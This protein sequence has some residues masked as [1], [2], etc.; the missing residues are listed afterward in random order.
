[1]NTSAFFLT[2]WKSRLGRFIRSTGPL[3]LQNRSSTL[4]LWH[5]G[6][7]HHPKYWWSLSPNAATFATKK[8]KS[9]KDQVDLPTK[10]IDSGG[11][12]KTIKPVSKIVTPESNAWDTMQRWKEDV[13]S[14]PLLSSIVDEKVPKLFEESIITTVQHLN[15]RLSDSDWRIQLGKCGVVVDVLLTKLKTIFSETKTSGS[16]GELKTTTTSPSEIVT[17]ESNAWDTMQQ[18]KDEIVTPGS[19]EHFD[20]KVPKFF[21]ESN[22]TTVQHLENKSTDGDWCIQLGKCGVMERV[23]LAK[24]KTIF[25]ETKTTGSAGELKTTTA[26]PLEIVTS[27]SNAWDTM[28]Q[29]KDEIVTPGG[30][31]H[32]DEKV[33][34]LLEESNISTMQHLNDRLSDGDW[35][36]WLEGCGVKSTILLK[37]LEN[38]SGGLSYHEH[39]F[40]A[41]RRF[42]SFTPES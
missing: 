34:K 12:T 22:I 15:D 7:I 17:P 19:S 6:T 35:K 16:A 33:P 18:W 41:S 25:S 4:T 29:W 3:C 24:L 40:K 36:G 2:A 37:K 30:S 13:L 28:Q 39:F 10:T 9:Q 23:L 21:E 31:E 38:G 26:S 14:H 8:K 32:F 5:S 27:E 11:A 20:D 1:M 42:G